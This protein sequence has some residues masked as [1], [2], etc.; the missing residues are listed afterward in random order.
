MR[1][2]GRATGRVKLHA[3]ALGVLRVDVPRLAQLNECA[4]VTLATL[5]AQTA[6]NAGKMVATLKILPY[7][8]PAAAVRQAE[9]IGNQ[10]APLLRLDPLTP[11]RAGLILSGSP[12]VQDRIIHSFQTA[13]RARLAALNADLVAIDFVPLDDEDDERR[14][15]QTIRAHL[16]A[17]HDL[18]ILA[19]ETAIMDRHDIAPRAVEQA[20]GT[21]ICFGAPVDPGNLLMLAYHGAVPILGAPG[22]ARSPKDNIVDLVLP[23]LLVGDRL[24]AADIVAFGHG[25]LLEDVPERPAPRARLTP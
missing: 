20:G 21:V 7:A 10:P 11:K 23:R 17:A 24:T 8:I 18:I 6:V 22:C 14:L 19:G 5:P 2:S 4:G 12:A 1:L 13:L 16:R 25:G 15:A 9:A 3:A